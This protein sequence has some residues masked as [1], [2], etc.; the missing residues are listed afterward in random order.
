MSER[1]VLGYLAY[2]IE[3]SYQIY[4]L[5]VYYTNISRDQC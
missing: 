5:G 1:N 2:I 3:L 4:L